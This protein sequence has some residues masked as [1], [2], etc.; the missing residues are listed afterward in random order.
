MHDRFGRDVAE[1]LAA[2]GQP[3]VTVGDLE[4]PC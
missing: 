4:G 1:E 3:V 2:R